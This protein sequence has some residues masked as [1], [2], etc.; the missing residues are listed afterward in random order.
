MGYSCITPHAFS[1]HTAAGIFF[2]RVYMPAPR[3]CAHSALDESAHTSVEYMHTSSAHSRTDR[4]CITRLATRNL[5]FTYERITHARTHARF[6]RPRL[7][8]TC[9]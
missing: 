2:T 4:T 3:T 5:P 9:P 6:A 1:M 7:L 8:C